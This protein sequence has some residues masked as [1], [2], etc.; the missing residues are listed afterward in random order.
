MP[1]GAGVTGV[2]SGGP[3]GLQAPRLAGRV[4]VGGPRTAGSTA[5]G[6]R[7]PP[8]RGR[9]RGIRGRDRSAAHSP[10]HLH[11]AWRDIGPNR[12]PITDGSRVSG[13][14]A[15]AQEGIAFLCAGRCS[16][17]RPISPKSGQCDATA[18]A[19]AS[20]GRGKGGWAG[21]GQRRAVW[22]R[23]CA[24][25]RGARSGSPRRACRG[26]AS[27][28][29]AVFCRPPLRCSFSWHLPPRPPRGPPGPQLCRAVAVVSTLVRRTDHR[30]PATE[31]REPAV[32]AVR[33][34][35]QKELW[36]RT[37]PEAPGHRGKAAG[38]AVH[39]FMSR[40]RSPGAL[41]RLSTA[42]PRCRPPGRPER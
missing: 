40:V 5:P 30:W 39:F 10:G 33:A 29:W 27:S 25:R 15:H 31:K 26:R 7:L 19:F 38:E 16:L 17:S 21:T 13:V 8:F 14:G 1:V 24:G 11:S 6:P 23:V 34:R 9:M 18:R 35:D 32:S 36:P 37:H 2:N 42:R 3:Q 4:R 12:S 20:T 22:L 28:D 41:R